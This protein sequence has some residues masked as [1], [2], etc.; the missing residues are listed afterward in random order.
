MPTKSTEIRRQNNEYIA[1]EAEEA[2]EEEEEEE[3]EG[4]E[5]ED[6]DEEEGEQEVEGN[7]SEE[8]E[9]DEDPEDSEE[10]DGLSDFIV[11]DSSS[12]EYDSDSSLPTPKPRRRL[13][14]GRK[15]RTRSSDSDELGQQLKKLSLGDSA[16]KS[17][18]NAESVE[19]PSSRGKREIKGAQRSSKRDLGDTGRSAKETEIKT[20]PR[21]PQIRH[22]G[23]ISPKK[24]PRIPQ[25]SQRPSMES[26]WSQEVINEW[27][28]EYSPRKL[29]KP[30]TTLFKEGR[31]LAENLLLPSKKSK[32]KQEYNS[33]T[34][35]KE[36]SGRK[37]EIALSFLAELDKTITDGQ[38]AH[39]TA[40][41]GGVKIIW[42]KTLQTTAGRANWRREVAQTP[43]PG[44][45]VVAPVSKYRHHAS[46]ELAEKIIDD[47]DRLLN[48]MAHEFC[49]LATFMVS[50]VKNNPH[51][52]EFKSW[53]AKCSRTFGSRGVNVTTKHSYSIEY[54][55]IWECTACNI[56]YKRHSKSIDPVR[57]RCGSCKG[58]LVQTKPI[59]R[60]GDGKVSEYQKFVKDNMKKIRE[61]FPGSP[62][63]DI[64]GIIGKRYQD[65]KASKL[66]NSKTNTE[67]TTTDQLPD[68][69]VRKLNFLD[70][71]DLTD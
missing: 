47:E 51:G 66:S 43:R 71:T 50:N 4:E 60:G 52:K 45:G 62:Q 13:V 7:E 37:Q 14:R 11:N 29:P 59:P 61:E 41:T 23:L 46:I 3:E 40:A 6:E 55:Y 38:I 30:K 54:K 63:K 56:E 48:V 70:I 1:L 20:P 9:G 5:D 2:E 25:P 24:T 22:H 10:S 35:K 33:R 64:M 65:Y 49:H 28:D 69:V 27:N 17:A 39:L 58:Q 15:P 32:A 21:S 42:S 53:G 34:S 16:P 36:F 8:E 19:G 68:S 26:F 18:D 31:A 67:D 44:S 57:H 12:L